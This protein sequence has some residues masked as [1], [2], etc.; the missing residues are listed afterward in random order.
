[1]PA[2]PIVLDANILIRFVLGEKVPALL[3]AHAATIDFLAPDTAFEEARKHLPTI[4]LARGDD[5]TGA[6]AV[7]F[8]RPIASALTDCSCPSGRFA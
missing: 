1:M 5:G 7:F 3:A 2:R 6:A 4:L 8:D